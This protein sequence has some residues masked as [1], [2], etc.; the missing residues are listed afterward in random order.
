MKACFIARG[1]KQPL[2]KD[3]QGR[4]RQVVLAG[5]K[6]D[7][8][9]GFSPEVEV[10]GRSKCPLV[11]WRSYTFGHGQGQGRGGEANEEGNEKCILWSYSDSTVLS[12]S[13]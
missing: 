12:G 11:E 3:T 7:V 4:G 9:S 1:R 13:L 6:R 8:P 10:S 5:F 2:E